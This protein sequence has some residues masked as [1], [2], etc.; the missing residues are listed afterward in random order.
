MRHVLAAGH[1]GIVDAVFARP[2]ERAQIERV[3]AALGVPFRGLWLDAPP[4]ALLARVAARTGDAS[5]ATADVVR[6]QLGYETGA[7][8]Q[9]WIR[10]D[11]G[12]GPAATLD[13]ARK[14]LA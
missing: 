14:A 9:G 8:S 2:E 11:A 12:A 1:A 4:E 3:A 6:Q 13:N 7:L 5:D 10:V